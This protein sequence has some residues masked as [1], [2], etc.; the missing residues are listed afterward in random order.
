MSSVFQV[1]TSPTGEHD[2]PSWAYILCGQFTARFRFS[3]VITA[4]CRVAADALKRS[5]SVEPTVSLRRKPCG[6]RT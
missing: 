4:K 5:S 3:V 6:G 1:R 2:I